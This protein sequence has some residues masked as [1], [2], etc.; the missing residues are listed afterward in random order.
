[1]P[2]KYVQKA[3]LKCGAGFSL[4]G[5]V[6]AN[7]NPRE[8]MPAPEKPSEPRAYVARAALPRNMVVSQLERFAENDLS[9]RRNP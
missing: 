9:E 4:R 3:V 1:M 7:T 8:L 5:L 2:A 6:L